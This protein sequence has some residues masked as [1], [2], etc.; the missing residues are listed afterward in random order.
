MKHVAMVIDAFE[1]KLKQ[2]EAQT[3]SKVR[4]QMIHPFI[5]ISILK[6]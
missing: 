3:C 4:M 1:T 2:K 5:Q 6:I